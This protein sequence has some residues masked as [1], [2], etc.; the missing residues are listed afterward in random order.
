MT[1]MLDP[2]RTTSSNVIV[3]LN[4]RDF[5]EAD[6]FGFKVVTPV[7]FLSSIGALP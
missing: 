7:E 3:T 2:G 1:E 6:R 4:V 5:K